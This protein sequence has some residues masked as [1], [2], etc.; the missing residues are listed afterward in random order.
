MVGVTGRECRPAFRIHSRKDVSF[1]AINESHYGVY[2]EHAISLGATLFLLVFPWC[3][4]NKS[5]CLAGEGVPY[6][7]RYPSLFLEIMEYATNCGDT[8]RASVLCE[9]GMDLFLAEPWM[10]CTEREYV[11]NYM[12]RDAPLPATMWSCTARVETFELPSAFC[13]SRLPSKEGPTGDMECLLCCLVP[14]PLPEGK[15]TA[16]FL[17]VFSNHIP[18]A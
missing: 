6:S 7:Y 12:I 14:M 1:Y 10:C 13:K 17:C 9:Q 11:L 15:N 3:S 5:A 4:L 2:L 18:E 16:S 8:A